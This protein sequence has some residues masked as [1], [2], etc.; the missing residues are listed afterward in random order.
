MENFVVVSDVHGQRDLL[1]RVIDYYGLPLGYRFNGDLID[2]GPDSKGTL[3]VVKE[4]GDI[5]T[6]ID[7]NHEVSLKAAL[8]DADDSRRSGWQDVWLGLP[9]IYRPHE[10]RLLESY[11]LE[12]QSEN[13]LTAQ[14]LKQEM[15]RLG[16]LALLEQAIPYY[17]DDEY[18]IVHA[19]LDHQQSW[20]KQRSELDEYAAFTQSKQY[21]NQPDPIFEMAYSNR[22]EIPWD[23]NKTLITGHSHRER[24]SEERLYSKHNKLKR[25][26]LA[27]NLTAGAPLFVF[28]SWSKNIRVFEQ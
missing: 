2:R 8:T 10:I 13:E 9:P 15:A 23:L 6:V 24:S 1:L 11:G 5:A 12:R 18:L 14:L 16:H 21:L 19:G 3:E 20:K 17:E 27:S 7:G 22:W 4:L 26:Q 25:V 28:E